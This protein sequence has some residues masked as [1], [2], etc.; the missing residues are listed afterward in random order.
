[1]VENDTVGSYIP[2]PAAIFKEDNL[3]ILNAVGNGM[4]GL[5][6]EDGDRLV[7]MEASE[8]SNGD[9]CYI[10]LP[11]GRV[12]CRQIFLD[13]VRGGYII[14]SVSKESRRDIFTKEVTVM[15]K[16]KHLIRS[17]PEVEE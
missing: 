6:I 9:I 11:D 17:Y 14:R 10:E 12:M 13:E 2:L 5:G 4:A 3:F 8:P 15:G 7:F 16:L 1:M